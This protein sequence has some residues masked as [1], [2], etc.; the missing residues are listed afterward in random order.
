MSRSVQNLVLIKTIDNYGGGCIANRQGDESVRS[1]M[2]SGCKSETNC[3][4]AY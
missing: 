1:T 4:I 3:S 2:G